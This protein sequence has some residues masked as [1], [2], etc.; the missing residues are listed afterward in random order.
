[1]SLELWLI[2][3]PAIL[4]SLGAL[5]YWASGKIRKLAVAWEPAS[6]SISCSGHPDPTRGARSSPPFTGRWS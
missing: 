6:G 4:L 2:V 5:A 1:M 3:A